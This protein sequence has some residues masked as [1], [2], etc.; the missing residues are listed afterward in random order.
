MQ[1]LCGAGGD[2]RSGC[3]SHVKCAC[4][5]CDAGVKYGAFSPGPTTGIKYE[6]LMQNVSVYTAHSSANGW[7]TKDRKNDTTNISPVQ[8][9]H[10]FPSWLMAHRYARSP[11]ARSNFLRLSCLPIG[12]NDI[13]TQI[14]IPIYPILP[15]PFQCAALCDLVGWLAGVCVHSSNFSLGSH[16]SIAFNLRVISSLGD[17][18]THGIITAMSVLH[19]LYPHTH[20]HGISQRIQHNPFTP[21]I[22]QPKRKRA[23]KTISSHIK[24]SDA[25]NYCAME[26][27]K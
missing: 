12:F 22:C 26:L 17:T 18:H 21:F 5:V 8:C 16:F 9:M 25:Q 20:S 7:Q 2:G 6:Q 24:P 15:A 27:G 11:F 10:I 1:R 4:C 13:I 3:D 23:V 19:F 14:H